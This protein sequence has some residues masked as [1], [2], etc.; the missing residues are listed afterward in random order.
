M[1]CKTTR[2]AA[3]LIA[4]VGVGEVS[5]EPV[6]V[7]VNGGFESGNTAFTS[8][9]GHGDIHLD[10]PSYYTILSNPAD[11]HP[12]AASFGDH[13]TGSGL[14]LAANGA[15]DPDVVVWSQVV[16]VVPHTPYEFSAW[17]SNFDPAANAPP[18]VVFLF[19]RYV[20][21]VIV[22]STPAVWQQFSAVWESGDNTSVEIEIIN[23][24][25]APGG[26]D[27]TLDDISMRAVPA[28]SSLILLSSGLGALGLIA[29]RR[30]RAVP[31]PERQET[32]E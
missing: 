12:A 23:R 31:T 13:T 9:Y 29:Y 19:D 6:D 21:G 5:A 24:S 4:V 17:V 8:E 27:L 30:R 15:T 7:I 26:N 2:A 20:A 10:G 32:S 1:F 11:M 3:L 16:D 18:V 28:P 14:M 22:A 25:I